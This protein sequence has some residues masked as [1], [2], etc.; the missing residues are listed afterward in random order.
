MINKVGEKERLCRV[1]ADFF[2]VFFIRRRG[3]LSVDRIPSQTQ[4]QRNESQEPRPCRNASNHPSKC[5]PESLP[6][7]HGPSLYRRSPEQTLK[8]GSDPFAARS[9]HHGL[10]LGLKKTIRHP[11]TRPGMVPFSAILFKKKKRNAIG[12]LQAQHT[13]AE[14]AA[15]R[16]VRPNKSEKFGSTEASATTMR[17]RLYPRFLRPPSAL[18]ESPHEVRRTGRLGLG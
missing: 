15:L 12:D 11:P 1:F 9:C 16:G 10:S 3:V 7:R 4:E 14:R 5:T 18:I 17:R 13:A 6:I 2:R 8:T